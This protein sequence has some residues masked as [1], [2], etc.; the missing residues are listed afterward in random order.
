MQE[1]S[2]NIIAS[3]H[4]PH[5]SERCPQC[6]RLAPEAWRRHW[7]HEP[8]ASYWHVIADGPDLMARLPKPAHFVTVL[9]YQ[10]GADGHPAHYRGPL[11]F[12]GDADDPAQVLDDMR[13][14]LQLLDVEYGCPPEVVRLWLSGGRGV[15]ATIPP[16]VFGAKEGHVLL[17]I[18][19]ARMVETLFP[20]A[21]APTLDR[22]IYSRGK[23][24]M[25]RLPNRRRSDTGGYKVP[26]SAAELLYTPYRDLEP[27]THRARHGVFW[28]AE[29]DLEPCPGLVQ[30]YKE[31][32]AEL[33]DVPHADPQPQ[34]GE[35]IL[36]GQRNVVLTSL[37]GAMQ[38]HGASVET[39]EA[40]LLA[41][42]QRRC[43]PPLGEAEVTRIASS[44][45]RYAPAADGH[46]EPSGDP[47][48]PLLGVRYLA[49]EVRV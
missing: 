27:L 4:L 24:R 48:R 34:A 31:T 22:G 12:E 28:P 5:N 15:H 32:V 23:G 29:S 25:W 45:G 36:K 14:C 2:R 1:P 7:K 11:Y 17:P 26:I 16:P 39:I 38:R 33:R 21:T 44:I 43:E 3:S 46:V 37:A 20:K 42:N 8:P 9:A 47:H 19:Y 49:P 10:A 40:A 30:L 35:R 13:R 41:E 18:I 6:E